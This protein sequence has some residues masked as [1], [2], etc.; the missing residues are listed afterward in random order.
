[1]AARR[2]P[3]PPSPRSEETDEEPRCGSCSP[4]APSPSPSSCGAAPASAHPLGN[5]TVNR[6]TGILV[7]PD[8]ARRSTTSSTSPR[9]R[10]PSWATAID[11]LPALARARVRHD[12]PR[13]GPHAPAARRIDL[14][15]ESSSASLGD[16]EGGLP[17]TRI[18]CEYAGD[19][20]IARRR[21]HLRGHHRARLGRVARDHR[22]RRPDDADQL[23]RPGRE[24]QRPAH[25][26]PRGP[27]P[28]AARRHVR[29]ASS[30]RPAGRPAC[31]P[32][33]R[34]TGPTATDGSWLSARATALLGDSGW[35]AAGLARPRRARPRRHPRALARSRQDRDGVLPLP[36]RR[37]LGPLGLRGRQ[38]R[39]HRAHRLGAGA[40][41][42]GVAQQRLR[43]G[44]DLSLAHPRHRPAH[45]R[46]RALPARAAPRRRRRPRPRAR[47]RARPR[48]RPRPRAR[49][50]RPRARPR[51]RPR[52]RARQH[53]HAHAHEPHELGRPSATAVEPRRPPS[54][55][56]HPDAGACG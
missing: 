3:A 31:C 24:H 54:P 26:L 55:R 14:T 33:A 15:L 53:E 5:F 21:D 16:G 10:P 1:M 41:P 13:P 43:P 44:P 40:G 18:T 51:A 49:R 4:S 45:R 39:H 30:S 52:P 12:R 27:A 36:A 37:L 50:P 22:R 29:H 34:T 2:R 6:Y 38:R 20:E 19:G 7:S 28:V 23:R 48:P 42:A 46:A 47:A 11:D 9:S 8:G 17:I 32:A 56:P 25:V 35:L